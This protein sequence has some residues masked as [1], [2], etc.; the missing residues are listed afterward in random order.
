[1]PARES[2]EMHARTCK[3]QV[4][5]AKEEQPGSLG[6]VGEGLGQ[7]EGPRLEQPG[8]LGAEREQLRPRALSWWMIRQLLMCSGGWRGTE[9]HSKQRLLLH[10]SRAR[11]LKCRIP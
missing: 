3:G 7:V 9:A 1:M 10:G 5:G 2:R 6:A 8:H 4:H 11:R